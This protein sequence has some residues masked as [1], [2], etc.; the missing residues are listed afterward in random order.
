[1]ARTIASL[2]VAIVLLLALPSAPHAV[3]G[4]AITLLDNQVVT[5]ALDLPPIDMR[6]FSRFALYG[7]IADPSDGHV[8]I[9]MAFTLRPVPWSQSEELKVPTSNCTI[10]PDYVSCPAEMWDVLG[11]YLALRLQLLTSAP[12]TLTLKLYGMR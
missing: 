11:P 10:T 7:R 1:M 3:S 6:R 12:T 4:K 5:G 9:Q 8:S 2:V